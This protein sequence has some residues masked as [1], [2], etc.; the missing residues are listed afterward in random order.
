MSVQNFNANSDTQPYHIY[1]D[2]NIINNDS[3]NPA[4]PALF[5][6][7]DTRSNYFL[8]SPQD[9]YMS[10]IRFNLQSTTLPVFIP[11]INLS[12]TPTT[13]FVSNLGGNFP[14]QSMSGTFYSVGGGIVNLYTSNTFIAGSVLY[15][16]YS[17]GA[18]FVPL[19][20]DPSNTSG[21]YRVI[22]SRPSP[23]S[24]GVTQLTVRNTTLVGGNPSLYLSGTVP[25]TSA[26]SPPVANQIKGG[27]LSIGY[28]NINITSLSGT[29]GVNLL[30]IGTDF[31]RIS[32]LIPV[33]VAG[34]S[35]TVVGTNYDGVYTVVTVNAL[36]LVV[37]AKITSTFNAVGPLG[38]FSSTGDFYNRTPYTITTSY[39]NQISTD[40][41][42]VPN[43][44][45]TAPPQWNPSNIGLPM[46]IEELTSAYYWVYNYEAFIKMVNQALTNNFWAFNGY[47]YTVTGNPL[48]M[49]STTNALAYQP[50]SMSWNQSNLTAIL[51]ADNSAYNRNNVVFPMTLF[52]DQP[53]STLFDSFP[54]TY[55]GPNIPAS[56]PIYAYINFDTDAGAGLYV[57][58]KYGVTGSITTQ[59]TA[60]QVY[61][62]HQTASLMNPVQSIVFTSTILPVVM[63]QVG[64]PVIINGTSSINTILGS[65]ANVFPIL[66]D[67]IVP[68]SATN[69]YRPDISY[70]PTGEYRLVDLYGRS[71]ANQMDLNV[72]WR[73]QYGLLHPFY[74][75]SGCSGS[76]KVMFRRK[77]YSAVDLH[78]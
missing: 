19:V 6:I 72:F 71:P 12:T 45:N 62:D 47:Y 13:N 37:R 55:V 48:P 7:K 30:T 53:L 4:E 31:S 11:Q 67:F 54:Y 39:T 5:Q 76:V 44:L 66:T 35:I 60:I 61:Q 74:L 59:Y 64:A 57:V 1:Y 52:F 3:S 16:G 68:F 24:Y 18:T 25:V 2:L 50:P 33:F 26:T 27:S 34:D 65:S 58:S 28:G 46:K 73:D 9:Y 49:S 22:D 41:I 8:M 77:D 21:Y 75:G 70:N 20:P 32:S 51:T 63:E 15:I 42:Y 38:Y 69:T 43:D 56:S 14:I 40:I 29:A 36:S 78:N 17:G 10:I 23:V